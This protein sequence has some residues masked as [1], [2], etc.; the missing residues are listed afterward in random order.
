MWSLAA[1]EGACPS[2][3][4]E[5]KVAAGNPGPCL[6]CSRVRAVSTFPGGCLDVFHEM[7]RKLVSTSKA[8]VGHHVDEAFA[9]K[10]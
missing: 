8:G 1:G 4:S 3:D 2:T 10:S 9:E 7:L 5:N 6:R